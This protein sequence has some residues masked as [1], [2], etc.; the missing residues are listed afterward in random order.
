M[1][2]LEHENLLTFK[3]ALLNAV[4]NIYRQAHTEEYSTGGWWYKNEN[5]DL[6]HM[7]VKIYDWGKPGYIDTKWNRCMSLL[8]IALKPG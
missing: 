4:N 1:L 2:C 3:V 8:T 6:L 7:S 5:C